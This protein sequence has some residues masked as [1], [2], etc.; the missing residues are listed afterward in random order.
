MANIVLVDTSILLNILGVPHMSD[1][2]VEVKEQSEDYIRRGDHL[3]LPIATVLETGNHI[4][5]NGDGN[6]KRRCALRFADTVREAVE[7]AN[8]WVLVPLPDTKDLVAWLDDFPDSAMRGVGIGDHSIIKS[9]E[10]FRDQFPG[11][12]VSVWSLDEDLQG[13]Q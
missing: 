4:A 7:N 3:F 12:A 10:R 1:Q 2:R 8:P 5:Q 11:L 13:Y 6:Q 9:W